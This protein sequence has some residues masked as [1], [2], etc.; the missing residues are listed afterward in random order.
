MEA[1]GKQ[2]REEDG[3]Q[4]QHEDRFIIDQKRPCTE[5]HNAQ[6]TSPSGLGAQD[7]PLASE[8]PDSGEAAEGPLDKTAPE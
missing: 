7:D 8:L 3:R 6:W 1:E 2:S 4:N 5:L